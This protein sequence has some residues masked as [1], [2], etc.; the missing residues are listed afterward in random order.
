M[1]VGG[2]V[3]PP[4]GHARSSRSRGR[5][6]TSPAP[7]PPDRRRP[8]RPGAIGDAEEAP[9][10]PGPHGQQVGPIGDDERRGDRPRRR[11]RPARPPRRRRRRPRR[12]PGPSMAGRVRQP[13]APVPRRRC[14]R[15]ST[16]TR[17][18]AGPTHVASC[19]STR[20]GDR[21]GAGTADRQRR[22]GTDI[23]A[24]PAR[25]RSA[26]PRRRSPA[27]SGARRLAAGERHRPVDRPPPEADPEGVVVIGRAGTTR[28]RAAPSRRS[29]PRR[30]PGVV[31]RWWRHR[32]LALAL[33]GDGEA[34]DV[35]VPAGSPATAVAGGA[36]PTRPPTARSTSAA[37]RRRTRGTSAPA[38]TTAT[39]PVTT[40]EHSPATMPAAPG[41][42][43]AATRL[44]RPRSGRVPA[45]A[46][47]AGS[48]AASAATDRRASAPA[49]RRP[50]PAEASP[51]RRDRSAGGWRRARRRRPSGT[52]V[53]PATGWPSTR[54]GTRPASC[55]SST[56]PSAATSSRAW[57]GSSVASASGT[58][59]AGE[60]PTTWRPAASGVTV[61]AAG[62]GL[63]RRRSRPRRRRRRAVGRRV[64]RSLDAHD[65]SRGA[66]RR[67]TAA[68]GGDTAARRPGWAAAGSRPRAS[69]EGAERVVARRRG[70]RDAAPRRVLD[71]QG[72]DGGSG[73]AP[74]GVAA[75]RKG[76]VG[77]PDGRSPGRCEPSTAQPVSRR[78]ERRRGEPAVSDPGEAAD[79]IVGPCAPIATSCPCTSSIE[80]R[81]LPA[82]DPTSWT[83]ARSWGVTDVA[84][85]DLDG[86]LRLAGFGAA[87]TAAGNEVLRRL[88]RL[89][90]HDELAARVVLQ[91]VLPGLLA[92]VARRRRSPDGAFEELVGAAWVTIR[93]SRTA[94]GPRAGRRQHRARRR[95][96]G[97]HGARSGGARR[98]RSPSIRTRS[99]RR[100]RC[101]RSAP[102]RSWPRC[103][104]RPGPRACPPT[105]LDLVR[106]LV[107][108][109]SPGR[110]GG[111]APGHAADRAQPPRPGHRR[112]RRGLRR[113]VRRR[114]ATRRR[115]TRQSKT[116][117]RLPRKAA[118]PSCAGAV[119][120][121]AAITLL[122]YS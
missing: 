25:R 99:T 103:S 89:G 91:R 107:V 71:L 21:R 104:P 70:H 33:D 34:G 93:A 75:G 80:W 29:R 38:R 43:A 106:D 7:R 78:G 115:S 14:R 100:R 32:A 69:A 96:P 56:D 52:G 44:G 20:A 110:A 58:A 67:S 19:T 49:P 105:D 116:G 40:V 117:G 12:R 119:V 2:G 73:H 36:R 35:A 95:V 72:G 48:A 79:R 57:W 86:L 77:R 64:A 82:P 118:I 22:A 63:R 108:V 55:N 92:T 28:R 60:R 51:A 90:R 4:A 65:C 62:P 47:G 113:V 59:T 97:V 87:S 94:V 18:S 83:R 68:R 23:G 66:R 15:R 9:Q 85:A 1:G 109:G 122:A 39:T 81:A 46:P 30:P 17:E 112:L 61:P 45:T 50:G 11:R 114:R 53:R 88:A 24:R 26:R 121:A 3:G 84:F 37:R 16:T 101:A 5:C 54:H 27:S 74:M 10:R 111:A 6:G 102:A 76:N 31:A 98:A 41:R 8:A 42:G 120:A 13:P